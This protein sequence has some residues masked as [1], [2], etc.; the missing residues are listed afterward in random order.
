M[1]KSNKP[2]SNRLT[3]KIH[4]YFSKKGDICCKEDIDTARVIDE[5]FEK[6]KSI[7]KKMIESEQYLEYINNDLLKFIGYTFELK[8]NNDHDGVKLTTEMNKRMYE[9]NR[10]SEKQIKLLLQDI[11]LYILLSFL[12]Y[13][14]YK[15]SITIFIHDNSNNDH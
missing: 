14:H 2:S 15:D 11:P 13:A 7:S 1:K 4:K 6:Y 10:L 12:G 9:N 3:R 8:K 5:I